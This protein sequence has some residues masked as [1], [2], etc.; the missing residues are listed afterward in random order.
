MNEVINNLTNL[1]CDE[2]IRPRTKMTGNLMDIRDKIFEEQKSESESAS[3]V[4]SSVSVFLDD[5]DI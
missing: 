1:E 3:S 4:S 5:E 2:V